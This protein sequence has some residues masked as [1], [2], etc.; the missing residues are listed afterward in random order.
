MKTTKKKTTQKEIAKQAHIGADFLSHIIC[1]DRRCPP[2]VA[3]RL[4]EVTGISKVTWV[5]GTPDEIRKAVQQ[6]CT[7]DTRQ[8]RND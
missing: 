8:F 7:N 2:K 6:V 5:W 4:E 1:G 3:L